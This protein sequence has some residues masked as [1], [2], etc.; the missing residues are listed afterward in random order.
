MSWHEE[1]C[2]YNQGPERGMKLKQPRSSMHLYEN[3]RNKEAAHEAVI[4]WAMIE[5][6]L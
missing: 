5:I 4:D 1:I 6:G 2:Y 3:K